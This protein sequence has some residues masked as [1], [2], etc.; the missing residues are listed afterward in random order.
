MAHA[1]KPYFVF[2]RNGPVHLNRRWA[3]VQSTAGSRGV[4]ISD[5]N[6]GYTMF[7]GS[8]KGTGYPLHSPVSP[9]I[10]SI[11]QRVPPHFNWTQLLFNI[12]LANFCLVPPSWSVVFPS[13][14]RS[15]YFASASWCLLLHR[16]GEACVVS[17][18]YRIFIHCN[19]VSTRCQ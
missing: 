15:T 8:V 12:S 5:G 10:P 9:S 16:H 2:R 4:R 6:A 13:F 14:I 11:R 7:R 3:S 17:S 19:W 18:C 1:Q